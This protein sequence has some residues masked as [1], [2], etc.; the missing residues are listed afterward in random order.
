MRAQN[1]PR[2][3]RHFTGAKTFQPYL[4]TWL[5]DIGTATVGLW[6]STK[7]WMPVSNTPTFR[8]LRRPTVIQLCLTETWALK[9][10]YFNCQ[11]PLTLSIMILYCKI[12]RKTSR[13]WN[14]DST[15]VHC[16]PHQKNIPNIINCNFEGLTDFNNV[17]YEYFWYNW[18][19]NDCS[20]SHLTHVC[21]C[22]TWGNR[23]TW[24]ITFLFKVVWLFN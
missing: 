24:N 7:L 10:F 19:P 13:K 16:V 9:A 2:V 20:S 8:Q 17:W 14:E 15:T 11:V 6:T 4:V 22:T 1:M 3:Q 12:Q 23:N 18:P 5:H 21:S